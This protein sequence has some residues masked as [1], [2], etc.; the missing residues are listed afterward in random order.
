MRAF[1]PNS[2]LKPP[3]R[4]RAHRVAEPG[5]A[6]ATKN[7]TRAGKK[8]T[9]GYNEPQGRRD[10]LVLRGRIKGRGILCTQNAGRGAAIGMPACYSN[11][12]RFGDGGTSGAQASAGL[13]QGVRTL[14]RGLGGQEFKSS[15]GFSGHLNWK[16]VFVVV[17]TRDLK[18]MYG[19]W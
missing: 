19:I 4:P 17:N 2:I 14:F 11:R 13:M 1:L 9:A 15:S 10:Q 12:A 5:R 7:Y 6:A 16:V 8:S 18:D 3:S